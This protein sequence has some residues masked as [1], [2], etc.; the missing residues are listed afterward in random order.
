[1]FVTLRSFNVLMKQILAK[2]QMVEILKFRRKLE[3]NV[4]VYINN[5]ETLT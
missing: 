2:K 4:K 1:M 5:W 3:K